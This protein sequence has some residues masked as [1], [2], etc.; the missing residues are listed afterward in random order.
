M[1]SQ[2]VGY[3]LSPNADGL[4]LADEPAEILHGHDEDLLHEDFTDVR[5]RA[6]VD[7]DQPENVDAQSWQRKVSCHRK[8]TLTQDLAKCADIMEGRT[9][10]STSFTSVSP[11]ASDG[12]PSPRRQS[13]TRFSLQTSEESGERCGRSRMTMPN[14]YGNSTVRAMSNLQQSEPKAKAAVPAKAGA[15]PRMLTQSTASPTSRAA[16]ARPTSCKVQAE[17]KVEAEVT[18]PK[19][20]GGASRQPSQ[21]QPSVVLAA[22]T[23]ELDSDDDDELMHAPHRYAM[24]TAS[25][26]EDTA[27]TDD[28]RLATVRNARYVLRTIQEAS[29]EASLA[30]EK[31][32]RKRK[33]E[34]HGGGGHTTSSTESSSAKIGGENPGT[35]SCVKDVRRATGRLRFHRRTAISRR[36]GNESSGAMRQHEERFLSTMLGGVAESPRR[37]STLL[38]PDLMRKNEEECARIDSYRHSRIAGAEA[39]DDNQIMTAAAKA[40]PEKVAARGASNRALEAARLAAA[41]A[42]RGTQKTPPDLPTKHMS[43]RSS[44]GT[45]GDGILQATSF[46]ASFDHKRDNGFENVEEKEDDGVERRPSAISSFGSSQIHSSDGEFIESSEDS[47]DSSSLRSEKQGSANDDDDNR[48]PEQTVARPERKSIKSGKRESVFRTIAINDASDSVTRA[49]RAKPRRRKRVG[50]TFA[51]VP[52]LRSRFHDHT[53][54]LCNQYSKEIKTVRRHHHRLAAELNLEEKDWLTS[55]TYDFSDEDLRRAAQRKRETYE[56]GMAALIQRNWRNK[57]IIRGTKKILK[58][59]RDAA[60]RIQ[61]LWKKKVIFGFPLWRRIQLKIVKQ[62]TAVRFQAVVRGMLARRRSAHARE[63]HSVVWRMQNLREEIE[64]GLIPLAMRLQAVARGFL[65]RRRRARERQKRWDAEEAR[66]QEER[67]KADAQKKRGAN[68]RR[69]N[70]W[71]LAAQS[72]GF[73][74]SGSCDEASLSSTLTA[75]LTATLTS[76]RHD[77]VD[78]RFSTCDRWMDT[79]TYSTRRK[80]ADYSSIIESMVSP[81]VPR[82]KGTHTRLPMLTTPAW[83]SAKAVAQKAPGLTR[84]MGPQ[85]KRMVR[86]PSDPKLETAK[87]RALALSLPSTVRR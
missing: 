14:Q 56:N 12:V 55:S 43:T 45:Q 16:E 1:A 24:S 58:I 51:E 25:A 42:V 72:S 74:S 36:L 28:P 40:A 21:N 31:F 6:F 79:S 7:D 48:P 62:S 81:R 57:R 44:T 85:R 29:T 2:P 67:T 82:K 77:E 46:G 63:L 61:A 64:V 22:K 34:L 71:D 8:R 66:R 73:H 17:A 10:V 35:M 30:Y 4:D 27:Q 80:Q 32:L 59:R 60:K 75:T 38:H 3:H 41:A 87:Q 76:L 20:G 19:I 68:K 47:S 70:V 5:E 52:G 9:D 39:V 23:D 26:I 84:R 78:S 86:P 65:V 13:S 15:S 18:K 54:I 50:P 37:P 33:K 53:M 69:S 83:G 49:A 11:R